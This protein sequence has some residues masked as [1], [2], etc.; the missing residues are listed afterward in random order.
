M[1]SATPRSSTVIEH[2]TSLKRLIRELTKRPFHFLPERSADCLN[3]FFS[4]YG[5]FGPPVWRDLTSFEHWLTKRLFYPPDA[6]ARWWRFIELNS[7]DSFDGYELFGQLYSEYVRTKPIDLQPTAPDYTFDPAQFDFYQHLYGI[8][9]RPGM[10]LGSGDRVQLLAAYLAGYFKGK[11][12]ARITL[13]RDEKEFLRFEAW[14]SKGDKLAKQYPW[15]RVVEMWPRGRNSFES[16]CANYDAYLTNF[17]KKAR[18]LEDLFEIVK[19]KAGT[20]IRR[21]KKL[22]KE[23]IR[24]PQPEVW[25]R[26]TANR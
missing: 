9:R 13:T 16:F 17:G 20:T 15:Y 25:W 18:G 1:K 14:L 10:Y 21:R 4:G 7:K 5:I 6:G 24:S 8:C 3:R 12:D 23:I 2:R 11:K 26:S 22:P 19:G